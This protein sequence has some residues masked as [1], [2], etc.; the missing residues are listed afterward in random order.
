VRRYFGRPGI[1]DDPATKE[2]YPDNAE[3]IFFF[4][5]ALLEGAGRAPVHRRRPARARPSGRAARLLQAPASRQDGAPRL[6]GDRL[7]DPQPGYQGIFARE[8]FDASGCPRAPVQSMSP[9]EFHGMVNLMKMGS[10]RRPDHDR[11]AAL[12][13]EIT[14]SAEYGCGLEGVLRER[15]GDLNGILNGIDTD[16]WNPGPI[17]SFPSASTARTRRQGRKPLGAAQALRA[18]GREA[19]R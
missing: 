17:R 14:T 10:A 12:R 6:A 1:Y 13:Y 7:H 4:N 18:A 19:D 16:V 5:R 3:R 8:A 2:G 11:V 9:F 15:A